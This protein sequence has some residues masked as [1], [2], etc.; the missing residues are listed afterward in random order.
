MGTD[1]EVRA[2]YRLQLRAGFDFEAAK[3]VLPYLAE[4]G[5]SHLYLS[6]IW[7]AAPGSTH[8]YDVVDP[9]VVEPGLGGADGFLALAAAANAQG[10]GIILDHVPN[11]MG[12]GRDNGWWWDVLANGRESRFAG[13]FDIDWEAAAG[14]TPG[15]VLLPVLGRPYG[16]VL[17]AGE[18]V[19]EA[20][21]DGF[22]LRYHDQLFPLQ[23]D[24]RPET[25][26]ALHAL[27]EAQPY[28][29]AW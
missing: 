13:H 15:R 7:R 10:L 9:N 1:P 3:A 4:L 5:V 23:A 18:L 20:G 24:S 8:G 27:L 12:I 21:E 22:V 25:T 29:L 11:H 19:V 28:R 26:E 6:P 2:T 17:E 16:E 14:A